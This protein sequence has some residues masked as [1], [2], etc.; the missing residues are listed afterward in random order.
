MTK[1]TDKEIQELINYSEC[2]TFTRHC[3]A[4]R[5]LKEERDRYKNALKELIEADDD[6][7]EAGS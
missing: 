7:N 1:L 4:I 6:Y 5:Q 3:E 2:K